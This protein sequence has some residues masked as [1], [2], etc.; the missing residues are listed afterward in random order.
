LSDVFRCHVD[1]LVTLREVVLVIGP[2][3]TSPRE[4]Y[5]FLVPPR[6]NIS[7]DESEEIADAQLS[8]LQRAY[9]M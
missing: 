9:L 3:V 1:G 7:E 6:S 5:R 4:M 2:V 8:V